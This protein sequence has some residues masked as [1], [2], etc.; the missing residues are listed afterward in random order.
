MIDFLVHL[1]LVSYWLPVIAALGVALPLYWLFRP[2]RTLAVAPVGAATAAAALPGHPPEQRRSFRRGGNSIGLFYKLP[3][4]KEPPQQASIVDRSM[5]GL[6][7][8]THEKLA[9]GTILSVRPTNADDIVPWV[10]IEVCMCRKGED[11]FEVGC[12]FIKTPPYSI[13]L[14]FG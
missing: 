7:I 5:G 14:L 2:R 9:D 10:D 11:C 13:L 6:C 8:L 4:Q 12:R 1:P 3:G